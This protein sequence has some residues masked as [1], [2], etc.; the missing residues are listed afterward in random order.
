MSR[1]LEL[2]LRIGIAAALVAFLTMASIVIW[3]RAGHPEARMTWVI[4][5]F[6]TVAYWGPLGYAM[7]LVRRASRESKEAEQ[8]IR[9][10]EELNARMIESS[11]DCI[12]LLDTAG[13]CKMI[14]SPMWRWIEE[15]GLRPVEGMPWV[16]AWTGEPRKAA[17]SVVASAQAGKVGKFQGLCHV[18]SGQGRWYDVSITPV[19]DSKGRP[20]R[21]LVIS[22]DVTASHSAEEKF[23]VLFDNSANAHIIFDGDRV[24]ACNQSA[25]EVLGFSVKGEILGKEVA[26]LSPERQPDGSFSEIKR[27]EIWETVRQVG[28]FRYEWRARKVNGEELPVEIAITPVW[29]DG[30]EV[31]LSVWTD[32]TERR[33]T[34]TLLQESETRFQA[35]MEHSPTLCFIKDD[36]GRM[37]FVNRVMAKAFGVSGDEMIGKTDLDWLAPETAKA[38]MAA[39]RSVLE[40]NRPSKQVE[41]ISTSDGM[42]HEW[43]VMKFPIVGADGRRFLGGVGMDVR[44]QR[45]A[46]RALMLSESTFREL[47]HDA[48]VAYHELD[49]EGRIVRVNT[50]ELAL[51]GYTAEEMV[52]RPVWEFCVEAGAKEAVAEKL[53]GSGD[54]D[55]AFQDDAFQRHFFHK[56]GSKIPVLIRDRLIRDGYG[57]ICGV[58]TTMQDI[59]ELKKTESSLR[60][61]EENYRKIFENAAEGIFQISPQGHFIN[62]N[63]ALAAVLGYATPAEL[64]AEVKD[65]GRQVYAEH[66]RWVEFCVAMERRDPVKNF[67]CEM[68]CRNGT[69]ILVSQSA[70]P[71]CDPEGKVIRYDGTIENVTMRR[72]AEAALS[73]AR[74]SALESVRLKTEFLANM[75]HEIRTPMN[76]IVGMT[77]LLLDTELTPRQRDFADTIVDSS[78]ALLE[79]INDIL[80]FSKIEAGMLTFDEIDFNIN[81]V[82]EGVVD[83]FSE[84]AFSKGIELSLFIAEDVPDVLTGDPGRLRQV[85]SNLVGNALKFTDK[86]E[87]RALIR[88]DRETGDSPKVRFEVMDTGIGISKEQQARLFQPFV[89]ADGS[90]T[91]RYGGTG[92]GLAICRRLVTQMGGDVWI[93]SEV[94]QGA[95]FFFTAVFRKPALAPIRRPHEFRGLRMLVVEP[96][97]RCSNAIA[98][99]TGE[100]GATVERASNGTA[101]MKVL[102]DDIKRERKFDMVIFNADECVEGGTGLARAIRDELA[103][104]RIK[105]VRVVSLD[106]AGHD[107]ERDATAVEGQIAKPLKSRTIASCIDHALG[108]SPGVSLG[109]PAQAAVQGERFGENFFASLRVLVAEDS[110]VN[111]KVVQFQLRKLGCQVDSALDGEEALTAA[112]QKSY[113]VILMDCQMPKVDGWQVTRQIREMEKGGSER[114]WIIAMTAHSLVGDRE[115]CI[116]NGMDDY[117]S[118]PVRFADLS[119]ALAQSPGAVRAVL[120]DAVQTPANVVCQERISSFRELEAESGQSVLGSVV[121]LFVERTPPMFDEV[122]RALSGSDT[123]R[124]ARVA[125]TIKGSC[126]NFGAHR[127]TAA[128]ELLEAAVAGNESQARLEEILAEIEREFVYVRLA[129]QNEVEAKSA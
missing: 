10:A 115:R 98:R 56:D 58:R 35:F 51:L 49:T 74:D 65:V 73:T 3:L 11:M 123:L 118:K 111:Q 72:Q 125:H 67:E 54:M 61:A 60:A 87:V 17:E 46:E 128:C 52:G 69:V 119:K 100:W 8:G 64:L 9:D 57:A 122:R 89:Q 95:R 48:P 24:L 31:L 80:D 28:H 77:G 108:S 106:S 33:Q 41:V 53:R 26:V 81:D 104:A 44:E 14:N 16:E 83:L 127:M 30:R 47:F 55:D 76:G 22:R 4:V 126:S 113:D 103:F 6:G 75:S 7:L 32:L 85:L 62:A 70:R 107:A 12:A 43:L 5:F 23:N 105:L 38:V 1:P 21:L 25:V 129:L 18:R 2:K 45:R 50:T 42:L 29:A 40:N 120:A 79:I 102:R 117:L 124:I 66:G 112:R 109:S 13:R 114:T 68:R 71:V 15:V 20:E 78:E 86:G 39:D 59:S 88:M 101:A 36:L 84:R 82:A 99:F 37:L 121:G 94:G 91:R 19:C 110:V 92:L 116:E 97:A 63:P 90:T 27:E 93:E 34:E 96:D